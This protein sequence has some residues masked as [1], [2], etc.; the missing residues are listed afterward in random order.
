MAGERGLIS[1]Y[2]NQKLKNNLIEEKKILTTNLNLI[3]HEVKMLT[4]NIDV[5]YLEILYR[6]KFMLGKENEIIYLD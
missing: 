3:E 5:D 2:S 6:K 4:D 1:Y